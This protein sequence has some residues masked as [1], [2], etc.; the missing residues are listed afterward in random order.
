MVRLGVVRDEVTLREFVEEQIAPALACLELPY[1]R[2]A[3]WAKD[4]EEL[5]RID[6]EIEAWK[7]AREVREASKQIGGRRLRGLRTISEEVLLAEFEDAIRQ[8]RAL[9]HHLVVCALQARVENV[10][11]EA[12]LAA[13]AYQ[14]I[15]ATC[16]AALKLIRVGQDAC[17]RVLRAGAL[18]IPEAIAKSLEVMREDAGCFN[19]LLEIGSMRHEFA[20]ERLFIS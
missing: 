14:S 15:A 9:G 20:E 1:V 18:Q 2:F 11:L 19:P 6:A 16:G 10:P 3:F 13:Y 7:L 8:D 12:A 4:L 5:C 17:Q